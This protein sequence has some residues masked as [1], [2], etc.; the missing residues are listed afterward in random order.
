MYEI[1]FMPVENEDQDGGKSGDAIA[2]RF[3]IEAE[4]RAA[5]VVI[6]GGRKP[7]GDDLVEH[8]KEYYGVSTV[9]LMI[10]THPDG[11]HLNGLASVIE[12]LQVSELMIHQPRLYRRDVSDFSNLEALDNL[13]TTA[14]AYGARLTEPFTGVSRFGGQLVVLGPTMKYYVELLDQH[15]AEAKAPVFAEASRS[16]WL[17]KVAAPF[18]TRALSFLP[19]ETLTD[20][21][22]CS[23]RNNTSVITLLTVN[24]E[25]MLFTGDAGIPALEA[26]ALSY[27]RSIG[28]FQLCPLSF[29][30]APH[31]GSRRNLGPTILD[32]TLGAH[33]A[34]F[35]ASCPAFISSA[36]A[37][38]K[39]PSPK[40]VNALKRRGCDVFATEGSKIMHGSPDA[41][42]RP[43]WQTLVPWPAMAEDDE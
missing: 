23:P 3:T 12:Q 11:D 17:D 28:S 29:F 13:I 33:N 31:H 8:I 16:S 5:V 20:D 14:R 2:L 18:T 1:D 4:Q 37:A 6:D 15:L 21:G 39:H 38:P 27:E 34:P 10:S 41:A 9:D 43:G 35:S 26:A 36:K 42:P 30:Q 7:V 24:Q 32:R 25:R 22:E 19:V 40:V